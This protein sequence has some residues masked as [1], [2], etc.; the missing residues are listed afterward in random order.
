MKRRSFL[1]SL[2]GT[3]AV[4]LAGTPLIAGVS[5][6]SGPAGQPESA[7]GRPGCFGDGRDWFLEKRFGMFA[8]WGLYSIPAWH[9]QHQWRARVPR[10]EYVKLA[11]QWNPE[12]FNPEQ[13]LD[14]LEEAGMRYLTLTTK[15]HD[16]FCLFDSAYTRFTSVHT[17]Y[18]RDIVAMVAD[19]C[20]R[21]KLP[22]CLYYSIADWNHPNYPNQGRHHELPAPEPGDKPDW[23]AYLEFLKKQVSELC[24][25]YGAI[26]GFWWDMNVSGYK[27]PSIN[28]MIRKLQP[29]AVINDRGFD[30][31]DFGT[32]ERD[33]DPDD[34][35]A[36]HRP[37]EA[38]ITASGTCSAP[39]PAT[40]RAAVT[41]CS[42]WVHSQTALSIPAAAA[43]CARSAV[44]S[45]KWAVHS[46]TLSPRPI[47]PPTGM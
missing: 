20:H 47:S 2:G 15:H 16:G 17:P 29:Q 14:L 4:T 8:H 28:A 46:E 9:E 26:H 10:A 32:P 40:S 1:F 22:L 30:A 11:Q 38:T 34:A 37:V 18:K 3:T 5:S 27:D 23:D 21:R 42:M 36:I 43:S 35:R 12:K 6:L 39:S 13:W 7:P 45:R 44:G 19:A 41:M 31:G 25:N 24:S 33:Y